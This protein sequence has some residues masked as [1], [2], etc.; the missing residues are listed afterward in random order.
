MGHVN[1]SLD[2]VSACAQFTPSD[3][4]DY[5]NIW[6][7]AITNNDT[8]TATASLELEVDDAYSE[9]LAMLSYTVGGKSFA[10][11]RNADDGKHTMI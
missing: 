9:C 11:L 8:V 10:I 5:L 6:S 2:L 4:T 7:V 1:D 3:G